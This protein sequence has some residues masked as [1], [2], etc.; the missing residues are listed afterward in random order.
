MTIFPAGNEGEYHTTEENMRVYAFTIRVFVKRSAPREAEDADRIMRE[1]VTDII[2]A[3]DSDYT[4][5]GIE[6]PTGYTFIN[7]FA[8][9]SAWGYFGETDE[10]RVAQIDLR[11]R[12]S[13]DLSAI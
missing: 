2:D 4:F 8:S 11:C 7:I 12:V 9:P 1:A 3:F 10:Y 5:D 6:N 13:V